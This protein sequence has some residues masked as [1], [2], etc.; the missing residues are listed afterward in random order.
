MEKVANAMGKTA[1]TILQF[2]ST[3][4]DATVEVSAVIPSCQQARDQCRRQ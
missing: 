4:H 1:G 3:V 2:N